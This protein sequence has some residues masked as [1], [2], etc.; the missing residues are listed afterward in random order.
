MK[1]ILGTPEASHENMSVGFLTYDLQEFTADC[2]SR[3]SRVLTYPMKAFPV[4]G[5]VA[6]NVDFAYRPTSVE[7]RFFALHGKECTP[8]GLT[9]TINWGAAWDCVRESRVI[10]L[11]GLQGGTAL[12][13]ALLAILFRR[14]LISV[15]QTLPPEWER[16]RRWWVRLLKGW[17]LRRCEIHVIQTPITRKTLAE[18]YNLDSAAFVEAPFESGA[19]IF[20]DLYAQVSESRDELREEFG[21]QKSECVFMY[22]GTLLRFKGVKTMLNAG[23][24]LKVS[25]MPFRLVFFGQEASQPG[26]PTIAEYRGIAEKLGIGDR[27]SFLGRRSAKDLAR[28]YKAADVFI[29]PTRRDMWPKVLVEASLAELPLITTTACGAAGSLVEHERTGLI[30]PPND[31]SELAK[32]MARMLDPHTRREYGARARNYVAHFCS[33]EKEVAGYM[34]AILKCRRSK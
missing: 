2:L 34:E 14:R 30:I 13:T 12:L 4:M 6:R 27:V 9:S 32:A 24:E 11:F 18:V 7:G 23:A 25:G 26:E 31:S 29:L 1:S 33:P 20:E 15:N 28:A 8:E 3:V 22:A 16:K 19:S 17:L 5:R 21:W 10:L